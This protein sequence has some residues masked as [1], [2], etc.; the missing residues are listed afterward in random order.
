MDNKNNEN[1]NTDN[2]NLDK[3]SSKHMPKTIEECLELSLIKIKKYFKRVETNN[4]SIPLNGPPPDVSDIPNEEKALQIYNFVRQAC[5]EKKRFFDTAKYEYLNLEENFEKLK[6]RTGF[7]QANFSDLINKCKMLMKCQADDNL[8]I[9]KLKHEII[10]LNSQKNAI[11]EKT[12]NTIN[13]M[14]KNQLDLI[15]KITRLNENAHLIDK[16]K[17]ELLHK[18]Q[19][20]LERTQENLL[21]KKELKKKNDGFRREKTSIIIGKDKEI[22]ELMG[23]L[24]N[25]QKYHINEMKE[26]KEKFKYKNLYKETKLDIETLITENNKLACELAQ[27]HAEN[28]VI[29]ENYKKIE[30]QLT[31]ARS[32]I[33][34]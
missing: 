33:Q 32:T 2:K 12:T 30:K 25:A 29:N 19:Q 18:Q 9:E 27:I 10:I 11:I 28:Y 1:K 34:L 20:L 31:N 26:Q 3:K 17:Q 6:Y 21:L 13:T 8:Y 15:D 5:K 14:K 23:K 22:K 16:G 4:F 7:N 24:E